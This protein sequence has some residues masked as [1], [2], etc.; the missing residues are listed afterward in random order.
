MSK[1]DQTISKLKAYIGEDHEEK[2]L[3]EKFNELTPIFKK[4]DNEFP[5]SGNVEHLV[6]SYSDNKYVKIGS[7][8]LELRLDKERN[9][10]VVYNHKGMQATTLDE[11]V[12]QE[13]ELYC[14]G[15]GEKLTEDILSDYLNEV[16][17]EILTGE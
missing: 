14:V 8:K 12:L 1:L 4:M 5:K 2:K 3:I 7:D 9:V 15:R 16:F 11:I 10:I 13:N 17:G 6:I